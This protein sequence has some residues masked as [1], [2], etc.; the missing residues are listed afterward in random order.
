MKL[1]ELLLRLYPEEFRSRFGRE[2]RE[3]HEDRVREHAAPL[4]RIVANHFV[5]AAREQAHAIGP[6]VRYALR[7]LAMRP[8]FA[9]VVILT[10]ALGVGANGAVFSIVN[11]V[12]LKALPYPEADR[13]IAFR[14][15]PTYW[16]VSEPQYDFYR[17]NITAFESYAAFNRSEGNLIAGDQTE[18]VSLSSVTRNFFT[19]LGVQP[20]L[21]RGFAEGEDAIRPARVVVISHGLWVRAFA[22]DSAIVGRQMTLN[23]FKRTIVGVM[24]A[25]FEYP[26]PQVQIWLPICSQR[27]CASLTTQQPNAADGW[28]NHYLSTVGRLRS[29]ATIEDVRRQAT[30]LARRIMREHTD[31]FDPKAPLT[32]HISTIRDDLVGT[33]RPYLAA[34]LGAVA[35]VLLIVCANVAN[36]LL[37]RGNGRSR[38]LALRAAIGASR[39]RIVIQLLTESLVLSIIGGIL[40]LALAWGGT[41][42]VVALAPESMPRLDQISVD[43]TVV[44]FSLAISVAAGIVFGVVPAFRNAGHAPAEALRSAGK[45]GGGAQRSGSARTRS[46]LVVAEVALAVI[47][48]T[49]A[50][51]LVRSLVHLQDMDVGFRPAGA[52]TVKVSI[53]GSVN[54]P[55]DDPRTVQFFSEL[56]TRVRALPGVRAAGAARW[57]PVVDAGGIW[58]IL[59]E[60]KSYPAGQGASATPQEVTTGYFPAMGMR[61][62]QGR[63]FTD[64]DRIGTPLVAIVDEAFVRRYLP[65]GNPLGKRFRLGGRD[66]AWVSIIGV[67][68]ALQARGPGDVFE[69]TMYYPYAQVQQSGYYVSRSMSL[70]VRTDGDPLALAN[71]IRLATSSMDKGV[72][73]SNVRTLESVF[74][75]ATANRRFSTTLLANFAVLALLLAAIGIYGVMSYSVSERT[76]EIG[77]RMALGAERSSVMGLILGGGARLAFAGVVIGLAG[78]ALLARW[79]QSLLVGVPRFDF[80]TMAG[81][82]VVLCAAGLL[83]AFIPARRATRVDPTEA[84]RQ[85]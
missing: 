25:G 26:N 43:R 62:V 28:A 61:I 4:P 42:V 75:T 73:V 52:L 24:P 83:A 85:G 71:P 19:T 44:L 40:G 30:A 78:A 18:R 21:G 67:V 66:S 10:V 27:T 29:G 33:T 45:G 60:G 46:A 39:R 5:S 37:A 13:A 7:S 82:A 70:I 56:L 49:G 14:H 9:A 59:I 51:M 55:Y 64:A 41:R 35:F 57:L 12:L 53:A 36:L 15:E 69:P 76:F 65:E 81:V 38:E 54:G 8:A 79:I 3:F 16:L 77:V 34:L 20:M 31:Q 6:D 32:P 68:S 48:L 50:G 72:P 17:D 63:D 74:G 58:D 23:G 47:L 22:S 80:A 11:G 84:L 1:I 2:M